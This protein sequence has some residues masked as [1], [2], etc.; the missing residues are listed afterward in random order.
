MRVCF[1]SFEYP[2]N[3]IGGA[4]T[5]AETI[6]KGLDRGIDVFTITRGERNNYDQKTYRML[7][8]NVGYWQHIL[9]MKAAIILLRRL[10]NLLKFDIVHFN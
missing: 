10:D 1:V 2:P 4:G 9:F 5:Y 3:I 8:L 7:T 6:V